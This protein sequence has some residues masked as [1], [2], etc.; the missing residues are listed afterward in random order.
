MSEQSKIT[1]SSFESFA[2]AAAKAFAQ[3]PGN[4]KREGAATAIVSRMWMT[5]GGVVGRVQ[6]HAELVAQR[7]A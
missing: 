4:Q 6:Y 1:G 2:D 7:S 3:V 5:K